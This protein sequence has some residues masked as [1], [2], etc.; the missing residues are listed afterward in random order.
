M[1]EIDVGDHRLADVPAVGGRA[2]FCLL[3]RLGGPASKHR[4]QSRQQALLDKLLQTFGEFLTAPL[5]MR[6]LRKS[7]VARLLEGV[8]HVHPVVLL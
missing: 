4:P 1:L 2:A 7:C 6:R 3:E 5:V 8:E